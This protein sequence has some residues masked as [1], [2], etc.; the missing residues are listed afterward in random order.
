MNLY[1]ISQN[2][3]ND[4]ATYDSA[5][6]C[7]GSVGEARTMHPDGAD[8]WDGKE[9]EFDDWCVA[10]DVKVVKIGT[11]AAGIRWGV[12]VASYNGE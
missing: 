9:Q 1:L 10:E 4:Y 12:L 11:A 7:A 2:V 5:V 6:V 8:S 3:N